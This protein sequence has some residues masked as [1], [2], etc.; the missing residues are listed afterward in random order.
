MDILDP[1]D[2]TT[3]TRSPAFI[4][5]Q[6]KQGR[7]VFGDL[8]TPAGNGL[9]VVCAGVEEC[10]ADYRM[11]RANFR[12]HAIECIVSGHW[13]LEINRESHEL[14]PGHVFTY[15]PRQGYRLTAIS[16]RARK[17]FVDFQGDAVEPLLAELRSPV[18]RPVLLQHPARM[19]DL[20][21]Q[22][23]E[24]SELPSE[25]LTAHTSLLA[26]LLLRRLAIESHHHPAPREKAYSAYQRARRLILNDH[27]QIANLEEVARRCGMCPEYLSRLFRRYAG[28]GALQFLTRTR[29][30]H[31]ADLMLRHSTSVQETAVAVG[32]DDPFHF[33]RVF[34]RIHGLSP[35]AFCH[36]HAGGPLN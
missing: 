5:R 19:V 27:L 31:A 26:Q 9:S 7:Y 2:V 6:V 3:D 14:G 34:K 36:V 35:R 30:Q 33:S 21:D 4:S 23:L 1:F 17:Y 12:Y 16:G 20:F 29:M 13:R 18:T 8:Q 10:T 11:E 32:F 15:G 24:C 22:L 25:W 28:E